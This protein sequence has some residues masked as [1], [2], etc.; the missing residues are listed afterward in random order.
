[1]STGAHLKFLL[2]S[3]NEYY[4]PDD[5]ARFAKRIKV[6]SGH[7]VLFSVRLEALD[8]LGGRRRMRYFA[9][10]FVLCV[11]L[12]I[13]VGASAQ[14]PLKQ[15]ESKADYV[16]E[17]DVITDSFITPVD[18]F[19]HSEFAT[20]G[21]P[22]QP[23]VKG[24]FTNYSFRAY[25]GYTFVR[26]YAAPGI[27]ANRNGF[28]Y[29]I[30]YYYKAKWFAGDGEMAATF[31]SLNNFSS[32]FLMGMG[33]PRVRWSG[34]R[35]LELWAHGLVGT[36]HF[37]PRTPYGNQDAFGYEVGG[38]VDIGGHARRF[39]YRAQVDMVGTHFFGTYQYSPKISAGIVYK[40]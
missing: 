10:F 34:P 17:T 24:V 18:Q 23:D 40:F 12:S 2:T 39:G 13:A 32:K 25:V 22:Q 8:L 33:G 15:G 1:M 7:A 6:Y 37:S 36:T 29:S 3:A 20:A 27:T 21:S 4:V 28:N 11:M 38:G 31:G 5:F 30:Q 9:C 19:S 26:F 16:A 14:A 35:E